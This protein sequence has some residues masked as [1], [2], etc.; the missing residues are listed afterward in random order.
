[1]CGGGGGGHGHKTCG[2]RPDKSVLL[3]VFFSI[4]I[5]FVWL[6]GF[7]CKAPQCLTD[8]LQKLQALVEARAFTKTSRL[9]PSSQQTS[10]PKE[11]FAVGG[12]YEMC[13]KG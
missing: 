13:C 5:M 9:A 8:L 6:K 12:K 2:I 4:I 3:A 11:A 1:M 7:V 10:V